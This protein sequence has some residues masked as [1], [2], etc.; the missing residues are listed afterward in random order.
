M[1][2]VRNA[3]ANIKL[4]IPNAKAPIRET[5]EISSGASVFFE[6]INQNFEEMMAVADLEMY[7][8]KKNR[9]K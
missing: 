7:R 4:N 8:D 6:P 3:L 9:Q 2:R 5:P 1:L